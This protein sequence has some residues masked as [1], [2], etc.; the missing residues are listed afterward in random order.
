VAEWFNDPFNSN[1]V[2][3]WTSPLAPRYGCD[4]TLEVGDPLV[5]V[6]F[7]VTGFSGYHLQ[8]EAFF[9]WFA[10]QSPTIAL[11]GLYTYLGTFK[12]LSKLC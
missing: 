2:P 8:D 4:N 3:N 12:T 1:V 6:V 11:N 5:K 9:S 7:T 10:R